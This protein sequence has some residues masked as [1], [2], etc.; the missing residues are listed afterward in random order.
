M[1]ITSPPRY[2]TLSGHI[3]VTKMIH[4]KNYTAIDWGTVPQL[5]SDEFLMWIILVTEIWPLKL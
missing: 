4:N 2:L 3:S 5:K 1:C